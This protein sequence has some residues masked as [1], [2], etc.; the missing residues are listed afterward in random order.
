M[1]YTLL[2]RRS[3]TYFRH[4]DTLSH[5]AI[6]SPITFGIDFDFDFYDKVISNQK[7]K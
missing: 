6:L 4:F 7:N 2:L 1:S 3:Q 5:Y